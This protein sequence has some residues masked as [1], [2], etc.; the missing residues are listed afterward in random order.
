MIEQQCCSAPPEIFPG[1]AAANSKLP[2]SP[3]FV[4][5]RLNALLSPLQLLLDQLREELPVVSHRSKS[6]MLQSWRLDIPN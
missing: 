2:F 5:L 3:V 4:G 6:G 1:S